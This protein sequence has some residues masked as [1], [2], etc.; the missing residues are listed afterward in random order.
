MRAQN[1]RREVLRRLHAC[2]LNAAHNGVAAI[3][4]APAGQSSAGHPINANACQ[5]RHASA[6]R[7]SAAGVRISL[8]TFKQLPGEIGEANFT[9]RKVG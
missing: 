8:T 6:V 9:K 1:C 5:A 4:H 2:F 3:G 7:Q